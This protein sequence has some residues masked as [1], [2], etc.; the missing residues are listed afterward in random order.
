MNFPIKKSSSGE[1]HCFTAKVYAHLCDNTHNT[2]IP[3]DVLNQHIIDRLLKQ[4][5][6]ILI[7][8]FSA[9]GS[10]IKH[11]VCLCPG[12]ANGWPFGAVQ[13]SKLNSRFIC[14]QG[15]RTTHGI[16]FFDQMSFADT[17]NG[18]INL[19]VNGVAATTIQWCAFVQAVEVG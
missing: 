8:K 19:T 7:L 4:P 11:A 15:H 5:Q 17:T 18:G 16:H 9:Y 10:L 14:G 6:V 2:V 1:D 12:C 3:I 13:N